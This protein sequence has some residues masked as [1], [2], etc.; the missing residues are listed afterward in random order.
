MAETTTSPTYSQTVDQR[1]FI[2]PLGGP[3]NPSNMLDRF[4]DAIYNK[5]PDTHFVKFM[6]SLLGPAGL[7]WIK[8]NYLEAKL[9]LYAHGFTSFDIEKYYG[10]PFRFGRILLEELSEDP[11]GSLTREQWEVIKSRDESYRKRAITYFNAM[12]AG[13]TPEGLELAAQS[14]LDHSGFIIENYKYLFDQHSDEPLGL[15]Y[16]GKTASTEEFVIV[17]RQTESQ[18][19]KQVISFAEVSSVS[20]TFQLEYNGQRTGLLNYNINQFEVETALQEL[21]N[22]GADGVR[23]TGGPNPNPFIVTFTGPLAGQD[24]PTIKTISNLL[25]NLGDPVEMFVRVIIG[26]VAPVDE[27][28]KLS[29][30]HMHNAQTAVDFLRPVNSLPTTYSGAGTRTRQAYSAVHASSSYVEA[31]KYVTGSES[32]DWPETDSLNWIEPGKEKE[33]RRIQGDLQAHYTQHHSINGVTAYT[34]QALSDP[35]YTR[36][37][38]VLD[39]YKSEHVGQYD[40][41]ASFTFQFLKKNGGDL[42]VYGPDQAIPSCPIPLEVTTVHD[43]VESSR[44]SN[45]PVSFIEG[46]LNGEVFGKDGIAT[47]LNRKP[48][49]WS[50]LERTAGNGEF[51]EIDLGETRLFNWLS[52]EVTRKPILL[53]VEYDTLDIAPEGEE[54]EREWEP[55]LTT[56]QRHGPGTVLGEDIQYHE[57]IRYEPEMPPWAQITLTFTDADLRPISS[58]YLRLRFDRPE[59]GEAEDEPFVEGERNVPYSVDVRNLRVSRYFGPA[60]SWNTM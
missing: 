28:V 2:E 3:T 58:R 44:Q 15:A 39:N 23:V 40:P 20:G 60:R 56:G 21:G 12:R 31:V 45:G 57:E 59:P 6:Y 7:G 18:S 16:Y 4:P 11:E 29:D 27:V 8:K 10:D 42:T 14:G 17:P 52:F 51:L 34:D 43:P 38:S 36:L 1:V 19:E 25:D 46:I 5:S 30:E 48:N 41:N 53:G 47:F 55:V 22:I 54:A 50:S 26:G 32:V 13:G 9:K 49:W 37:L 24:V 33:A 35:D